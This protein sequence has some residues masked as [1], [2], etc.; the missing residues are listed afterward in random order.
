MNEMEKLKGL[1]YSWKEYNNEHARTYMDWAE[2]VLS[3]GNEDLARTFVRLYMAQKRLNRRL[4][5]ASRMIR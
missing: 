4:E 5:E 2:K 3:I 1:L